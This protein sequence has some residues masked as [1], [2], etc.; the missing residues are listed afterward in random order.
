MMRLASI[1]LLAVLVPLG[2]LVREWVGADP[3]A[4]AA[5][6]Y[7]ARRYAEA[8]AM[9]R[10]ALAKGEATPF[11]RLG[12]GTALLRLEKW[13]E[14]RATLERAADGG[15]AGAGAELRLRAHYNAGNA[16]LEPVFRGAV[17]HDQREPRLRRAVA[18]YRRALLLAPGDRDAKWNLE[19]AQRLLDTQV[20]GGAGSEGEAGGGGDEGESESPDTGGAD[21]GPAAPAGA[22]RGVARQQ[23]EQI[24]AGAERSER[25][26]QRR[27]LKAGQGEV[28]PARDW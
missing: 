4:E 26:V 14:A 9:Y 25:E 10:Q 6:L 21:E 17:T 19:L 8:A 7:R 20:G 3:A 2:D 15:E 5:R 22:S 16:D 24:L 11:E 12:L 18:R 27:E 23:A 28:R 1:L 13:D